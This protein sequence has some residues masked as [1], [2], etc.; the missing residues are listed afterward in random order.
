MARTPPCEGCNARAHPEDVTS[1]APPGLMA[2]IHG[3]LS[4]V[5]VTCRSAGRRRWGPAQIGGES[6]QH[7]GRPVP[8]VAPLARRTSSRDERQTPRS[9]VP[10]SDRERG[11]AG[12]GHVTCDRG[13]ARGARSPRYRDQLQ[14]LAAGSRHAHAHEQ[15]GPGGRRG[16]GPAHRVR[17][18]RQGGARLEELR[19]HRRHAAPPQGRRD[20]AGA[21]GQAGRRVPDARV[22]AAR[23]HRQRQ[24]GGRL[25]QLGRVPPARRPGPD[26]VRPDDG[27]QLD[28]HR[29][30]GHPAGHLPD[31]RRRR[32]EALRRR[33]QRPARAHRRPRRHGRRPAAGRHHGRRRHD[34]RRG[35]PAPHPASPRD[36]YLDVA[37]SSLDEALRWP[38]KQ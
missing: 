31:V 34:L 29:H 14:G 22:R 17:R 1:A 37:A 24:P 15:P 35:R 32:A 18:R 8:A 6:V 33:P 27:R 12:S 7:V 28:L 25:G 13:P 19:R 10:E 21:V 23:A 20:A 16:A 9:G 30:A 3:H 5:C 4:R 11:E 36:G 26:D 2:V 38:T